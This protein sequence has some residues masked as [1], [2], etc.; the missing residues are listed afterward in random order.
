L[1][2]FDPFNNPL[3]SD[4]DGLQGRVEARIFPGLIVDVEYWDDAELMG[5]HWTAGVRASI[6]FSLYSL[7]TARNHSRGHPSSSPSAAASS[8]TP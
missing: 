4:F 3:G 1:T 5:G 8:T 2:V 6:P 7:A